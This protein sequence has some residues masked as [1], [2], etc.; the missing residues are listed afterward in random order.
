M[1]DILSASGEILPDLEI[2]T[3]PAINSE[4]AREAALKKN[5]TPL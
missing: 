2:S 4:A 3:I 1:G 5:R